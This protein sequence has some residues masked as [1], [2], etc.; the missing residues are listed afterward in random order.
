MLFSTTCATRPQFV[1]ALITNHSSKSSPISFIVIVPVLTRVAP[2]SPGTIKPVHVSL[3]LSTKMEAWLMAVNP[4]GASRPL[5]TPETDSWLPLPSSKQS[6]TVRSQAKASSSPHQSLPHASSIPPMHGSMPQ[7]VKVSIAQ[8]LMAS[9]SALARA[10]AFTKQPITGC[11][12]P[13][14]TIHNGQ[15]SKP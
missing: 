4:S 12:L 14:R 1:L 2:I 8:R 10:H 11:A 7:A 6:H 5:A 13:C 15:H 9:C 3:A